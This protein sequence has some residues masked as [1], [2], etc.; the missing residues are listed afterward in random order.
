MIIFCSYIEYFHTIIAVWAG[1][2]SNSGA[3]TKSG[4]LTS[5][6]ESLYM[7]LILDNIK[8]VVLSNNTSWYQQAVV[9]TLIIDSGVGQECCN[10]KWLFILYCCA[11]LCSSR[12]FDLNVLYLLYLLF[13]YST[14]LVCLTNFLQRILLSSVLSVSNIYL[15]LLW[16]CCHPHN[17]QLQPPS[18]LCNIKTGFLQLIVYL[19]SSTSSLVTP[20]PPTIYSICFL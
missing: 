10:K 7:I 14:I 12:L 4:W 1:K 5:I 15:P 19:Y 9:R 11:T 18:L 16:P 6:S 8:V 3:T 2:I 20:G 17:T 13:L